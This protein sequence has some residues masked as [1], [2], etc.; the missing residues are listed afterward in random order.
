MSIEYPKNISEKVNQYSDFHFL[1]REKLLDLCENNWE[2]YNR[3]SLNGLN[4]DFVLLHSEYGLL[5][6]SIHSEQDDFSETCKEIQM[7]ADEIIIEYLGVRKK[8]LITNLIISAAYN[9]EEIKKEA[10]SF[11]DA[12]KLEFRT[13]FKGIN[14][15]LSDILSY[16]GELNFDEK[17]LDSLRPWL[18][19][20][21]FKVEFLEP[22]DLDRKQKDI[23][24]NTTDS[25]YRKV[26]GP[27]GS[28]KTLV[29][30]AK[31]HHLI[32]NLKKSKVLV[33]TLYRTG[34]SLTMN[35]YRRALISDP[36]FRR[37]SQKG[38]EFDSIDEEIT[39]WPVFIH[40]HGLV[41]RLKKLK[42]RDE[43]ILDLG[44]KL[45]EEL[46]NG[47][48]Q[49]PESLKFDA[50]LI[51]EGQNFSSEEVNLCRF[52]LK[53]G[54]ELLFMCDGT[55]DLQYTK[56]KWGSEGELKGSKMPGRWNELSES[57]RLPF[58]Y[59][60]HIKR[61]L[62][63]FATNQDE[64]CVPENDYPQDGEECKLTWINCSES[65]AIEECLD[66]ILTHLPKANDEF[67][68][69]DLAFL[70]TTKQRG[71][72]VV[73]KLLDKRIK[74]IDTFP[75]SPLKFK[76]IKSENP[77]T[78][79]ET[80]T[81]KFIEDDNLR[82]KKRTDLWSVTKDVVKASS[83]DSF[84]GFEASHVVFLI[85]SKRKNEPKNKYFNRIYTGLTRLRMGMNKK[86]S[87]T[88]ICNE[89]LFYD[90]GRTWPIYKEA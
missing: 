10:S 57:Y 17:I 90:Y 62:D 28:G 41:S 35:A 7:I 81:K 56:E 39:N 24:K 8:T 58:D 65:K 47:A 38:F 85:E 70:S 19:P 30:G 84:Q 43:N 16:S 34:R 49:M 60:P 50:V 59:I 51:D 67:S 27:S 54:G 80:I 86:S 5:I 44:K 71:F 37:S 89:P 20:N 12:S 69:P 4:P 64:T 11:Y 79:K 72:E 32:H 75:F 21:D 88:V 55:Q 40:F 83:L 52:F 42:S 74:L 31:A 22:F 13:F 15:D 82:R 9:D 25:G 18:R 1:V 63:L 66:N 73:T 76:T 6:V 77:I 61:Y 26:R 68:Y 48:L 14:S 3:P 23:V 36:N 78:G 53:K 46:E 2:I 29:I 33:I 45:H 87:M